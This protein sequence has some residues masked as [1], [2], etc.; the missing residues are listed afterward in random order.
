M[1]VVDF[2]GIDV[3]RAGARAR[4]CALVC[5]CV[6]VCVCVRACVPACVCV[7]V[8]VCVYVCVSVCVCFQSMLLAT[9]AIKQ[10]VLHVT[11][12]T[13]PKGSRRSSW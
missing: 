2:R 9:A 3:V 4:A 6:C 10:S 13:V 5:V 8:C 11:A 1:C 7:C 12:A